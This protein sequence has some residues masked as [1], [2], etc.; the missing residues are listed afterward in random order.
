MILCYGVAGFFF[1]LHHNP[2]AAVMLPLIGFQFARRRR[3]DWKVRPENNRKLLCP[4][5][6]WILSQVSKRVICNSGK[7]SHFAVR[8]RS[9]SS[10]RTSGG[11][12]TQPRS[13]LKSTGGIGPET[14]KQCLENGANVLVAGT[15]IFRAANYADAFTQ[16][17]GA[18][19]PR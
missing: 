2:F 10:N 3:P 4:L 7:Q 16:L 1:W 6:L 19:R 9:G 13:I 8:S 12:R 15:A 18:T 5:F 17:R 14:A 11:K